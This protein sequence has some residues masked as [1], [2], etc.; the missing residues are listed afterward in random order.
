VRERRPSQTA[1]PKAL[2]SWSSGKDSAWALH[3]LRQK[4]E[5]EVVALLTTI[6]L[7]HDRVAM[8]AVRTELLRSQAEAAGVPLWTVPIPSPCSNADYEAAMSTALER[9]RDSGITIAAFGDLFLEDIRRY[10]EEKLSGT[11]LQPTFPIWGIP[12]R[13]L[14]KD[15]IDGGLRARLTCVDPKQLA[16]SFAGREFDAAL[17][18]D[19]PASV[20]P[21]GERGEFHTFAYDGPMFRRKVI[22][23][24]GEVVLRDGFAFADLLPGD[25]AA[26][27][28]QVTAGEHP[29]E[30]GGL[31]RFDPAW[32]EP[33]A[34][35]ALF[36]E[37]RASIAWSRGTITLFGREI[38]EPRLTAWFGDAD[39]T[40]SG[41]TVRAAPWPP[42]LAMLRDRVE[43]AAGAPL[44]A[45]LLNLYRD[46]SDR[47]GLHSDDEP[48]LGANPVVA[49]VSLGETRKFVLQPK[50]KSARRSGSYEIALG[51]GSLLVMAGS[52]QH[53]YRH[54]VP[55][56]PG[57]LGERI[58][59][60]FRRVFTN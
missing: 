27:I 4:G 54:G 42:A 44:N 36:R 6:N 32:L 25:S 59:L 20:D 21:C 13:D 16:A 46:G 1:R 53:H 12:T 58:N 29:L 38:L 5:V 11:G 2:L 49:S 10:R 9:A 26:A 57:C 35:D 33:R 43:Q 7:V 48:V 39:Y 8:H 55:K 30:R 60:T 50:A 52:C 34:A 51:H 24:S 18:E 45:V 31:L 47:M 28:R 19:L 3:V 37:L 17:L 56:Q 14:A 22:V 23:R 15:M 40:Y 41:R